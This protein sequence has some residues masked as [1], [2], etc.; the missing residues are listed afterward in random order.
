VF[1][2]AV[3]MVIACCANCAKK[4]FPRR[5]SLSCTFESLSPV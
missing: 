1:G 4:R 5:R 2:V 3:M